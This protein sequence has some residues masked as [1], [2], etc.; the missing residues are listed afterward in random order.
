MIKVK[1]RLHVPYT[2]A[3]MYN[4]VNDIEHYPL[5][6]PGCR[7]AF[8]HT[9]SDKELTATIKVAKKGLEYALTTVN[10]LEAN[11]RI[12]M[13]LVD[14]PFKQLEGTW[15]FKALSEGGCAVDIDLAFAFKSKLFAL[16]V[17]PFVS[18]MTD[19]M[20]EAFLARAKHLYA[21]T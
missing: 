7:E 2:T 14:G 1:K 3:E 20:I 13:R 8:I 16:A 12:E 15:Q 9:R 19:S 5:F 21:K 10:S 6:L 18:F 11:H 17:G 4:L